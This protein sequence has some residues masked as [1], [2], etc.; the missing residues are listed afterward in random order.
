MEASQ[1]TT[2]FASTENARR[3]LGGLSGRFFERAGVKVHEQG[4]TSVC[5]VEVRAA[6]PVVCCPSI[7]ILDW[8]S[9]PH[10]NN[11]QTMR[12]VFGAKEHELSRRS[13]E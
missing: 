8:T 11:R 7:P 6:Y 5:S 2:S 3:V 10:L 9:P 4:R 12:L 1:G 13:T